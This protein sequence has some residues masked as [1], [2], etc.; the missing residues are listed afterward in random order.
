MQA[1][2]GIYAGWALCSGKQARFFYEKNHGILGLAPFFQQKNHGIFKKIT[3]YSK[4]SRNIPHF[5]LKIT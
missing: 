4:K 5:C 1:G 2:P 3:E